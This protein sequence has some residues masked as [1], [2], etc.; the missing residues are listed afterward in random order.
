MCEFLTTKEAAT[1]LKLWEEKTNKLTDETKEQVE[2]LTSIKA[3]ILWEINKAGFPDLEFLFSSEALEQIP[4]LL[5]ELLEEEKEIF[6]KLISKNP[7]DVVFDDLIEETVLDYLFWLIS[8]LDSVNQSETTE[9]IIEDFQAKYT[10]F[11]NDRIYNKELY[12]IYKYLF[13]SWSLDYEQ[14]RI[15]QKSIDSM[16]R[17]W[18]ALDKEDQ[19]RVK[20]I[21]VRL[22]KL[23]QDFS[24]N[25]SKSKKE[26]SYTITD[27]EII[28]ELP[29]S[30]LEATKTRAS[31]KWVEWYLFDADPTS[32]TDIMDY[33]SDSKVRENFSKARLAFASSWE[34]DN[35]PL[36]IETLKLKEEKAKILWYR[37][38]A[39]F[40]LSS[41]M[42]NSPEQIFE[43][44]WWIK[45]K[46]REKALSEIEMLKE[47]FSLAKMESWDV[48]Y[49]ERK[50]KE[51]KYDIDEKEIKKYL[52]YENVMDYLF[53][54]A[55]N[56]YWLELKQIDTKTYSP[57]VKVYEVY[58][59]NKLIS[60]YFTDLF[61][62]PDKKW[63]AWA[64]NIRWRKQ[65]WEKEIIPVVLNVCNYQ[66]SETWDILLTRDDVETLFHEFG[67]ALHEMLSESKYS[68]LSWFG[69]EWDFVEL[70]SQIN[71]N[72]VTEK[73]SFSLLAKHHITWENLPNDILDKIEELKTLITWIWVLWQNTYALLDMNL[74]HMKAPESVEELDNTV[75]SIVNDI[76]ISPKWPEYKMH[77][78][79]SHIFAGWYS[80]WYYSYMWA[81]L[82]EADVFARIKEMW[83]F[84]RE[85]GEKFISTIL[86]QG[87]RKP[88]AELF[89]DFMWRDLDNTAFMK[90][91]WL[92]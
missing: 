57:D 92:I 40:S 84:D 6:Q 21:N 33:C 74:H 79:F 12:N 29:E 10:A 5:D 22:A 54:H 35:R 46:A 32:Y 8:H 53:E 45:D 49:Y 69:V 87:T 28:K 11:S 27:F 24:S 2:D 62:N 60:Y 78:S 9:K 42:A 71:E 73:E 50:L 18:I 25:V 88:A 91:K 48:Q 30:T 86:G 41:K 68:E 77:A 58:K 7:E 19:E 63:W 47:Y 37:T 80:A 90:R 56:F 4:A 70:P 85:V 44:I 81:E 51:E 64:N 23:K 75:L 55:K 67:H 83:M 89:R 36:I 43:L 15:V 76:S 52:K 38:H 72:W 59:N 39:E 26:F 14:T 66:K 65:D 82:L 61:Y 17:N 20:E 31:E 3:R 34:Y 1:L 16:E 13:N